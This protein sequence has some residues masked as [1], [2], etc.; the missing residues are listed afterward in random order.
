MVEKEFKSHEE[1]ISLLIN[2]GVDIS[3]PE[4]KSFTIL[5]AWKQIVLF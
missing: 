4:H 5:C 1:L 2:R 3:T